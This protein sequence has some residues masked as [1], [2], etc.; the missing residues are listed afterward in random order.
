MDM[1]KVTRIEVWFQSYSLVVILMAC[2]GNGS[3]PGGCY[4]MEC[5]GYIRINSSISPGDVIAPVSSPTGRRQY[6]TI[7]ALK[8]S[9]IFSTIDTLLEYK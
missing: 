3:P 5:T 1:V 2:Q 6:L 9:T 8:V 4:N 7:R